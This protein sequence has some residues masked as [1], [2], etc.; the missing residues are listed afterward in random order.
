VAVRVEDERGVLAREESV[1]PALQES[2]V[3]EITVVKIGDQV[4]SRFPERSVQVARHP[5]PHLV[6]AVPHSMVAS[7]D[8]SANSFGSI[9]GT[10]IADDELEVSERLV[11]DRLDRGGKEF[12]PT[13]GG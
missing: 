11:E 3:I 12:G 7:R 9:R 10:I 4:P 8:G 6:P 5:Q 1:T 13:V 2:P